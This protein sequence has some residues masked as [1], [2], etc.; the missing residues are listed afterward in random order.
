MNAGGLGAAADQRID[1]PDEHVVRQ[2]DRV[3]DLVHDDVFESFADDLFHANSASDP[4]VTRL[5]LGLG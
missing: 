3:G 1:R 2:E 4:T 5:A